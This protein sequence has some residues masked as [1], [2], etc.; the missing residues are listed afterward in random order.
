[1]TAPICYGEGLEDAP[2]P[3]AA[4][5]DSDGDRYC[6]KCARELQAEMGWT[7]DRLVDHYAGPFDDVT[8]YGPPL[9]NP[10][11]RQAL[12]EIEAASGVCTEWAGFV[13]DALVEA[14]YIEPAKVGGVS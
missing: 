12:V 8:N 13:L 9:M 2:H 3:P 6:W 4:Y 10:A 1:M 11:R 5:G 7:D 14:G